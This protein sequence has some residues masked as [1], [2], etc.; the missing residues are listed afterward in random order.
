MVDKKYITKR[1]LL[2]CQGCCYG[3]HHEFCFPCLKDLLGQ[4]GVKAWERK[5]KHS[6]K[7]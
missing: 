5:Q 7:D 4:E 3:K 6:Q 2:C 1:R